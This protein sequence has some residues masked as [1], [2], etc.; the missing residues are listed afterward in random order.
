M[1]ERI[2]IAGAGAN[3]VRIIE[4]A[5]QE[6]LFTIAMDGSADAPGLKT[7]DDCEV[8][9]IS[10]GPAVLEA[11]RK[12]GVHGIYP[13][14]EWAVE[15]VAYAVTE[16][17]LPGIAPATARCVRNK[18]ALRERLEGAG[19]ANPGF[20]GA[21]TLGEAKSVLA[22]TGLPAIVKPA[23]GN[24]SRGV[25]RIDA[26][27]GLPP[28]FEAAQERARCGTVL[29]E[30]YLDGEEYNVDGL[31]FE[32]RYLLGGITAK[33]RSAPPNRFDWGIY[34]PPLIP[35][36]QQAILE[37]CVAD[38]L[39]AVGFRNGTTHAEVM[40]TPEG[41]RIVEVA[42]RPGG[43]RI[44][45]DLIPLT[46]GWD[47]MADA[48]RIALGKAPEGS[49]RFE[50]GTAVYWFPAL[51]GTVHAVEG[52]EAARTMPHVADL[53]VAAKPGDVVAEAVDCAERDK[54]GYVLT[55]ADT[56][57]EAIAAAQAARDAV[58]IV[59]R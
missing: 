51:A 39:A 13:A 9:D 24:A 27:E 54:L 17:G 11:A 25:R 42:G 22:H 45:T 10:S 30:S 50:R 40:L 57:E 43:G 5:R 18:L 23:D 56:V 36:D 37:Q 59:T 19:I 34:M 52:A 55:A 15:A 29:I 35:K 49:H 31:V 26:P 16:L 7:A 3:Q 6:N 46:Y 14:A 33:D 44:P 12:H 4:I 2:L 38:A 1:L 48:L 32:G 41:P 21:K 28:A 8:G 20:G 58:R 53:A 47:Y